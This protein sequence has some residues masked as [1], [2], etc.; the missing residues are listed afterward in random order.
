EYSNDR[1]ADEV[2]VN[3][4]NRDKGYA[5]D[6]VRVPVPGVLTPTNP[7]TLDFVGC[8]DADMAGR[9]ANL[10]AASQLYHRRR[11]SWETDFEGLVAT[12]GDVVL[13]SHDLASWSY[14]GRLLGGARGQL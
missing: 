4:S 10:I 8:C 1:T 6:Q 2:I 13:L 12:R 11:V 5:V 7:V 3:F 14:S 9:E